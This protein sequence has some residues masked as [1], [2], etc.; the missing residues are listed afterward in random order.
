MNSDI[1][2]GSRWIA[3][4]TFKVVFLGNSI[5]ITI[6]LEVIFDC[7][8]DFSYLAVKIKPCGINLFFVL[9]SFLI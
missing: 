6:F 9:F 1:S 3:C 2:K 5:K 7:L 8:N 4:A